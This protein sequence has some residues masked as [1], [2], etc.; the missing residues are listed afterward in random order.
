MKKLIHWEECILFLNIKNLKTWYSSHTKQ[1]ISPD[2]QYLIYWQS[3]L[4]YWAILPNIHYC[5]T[6]RLRISAPCFFPKTSALPT[7]RLPCSRN[8]HYTHVILAGTL[9]PCSMSFETPLSK[10]MH[11]G[12]AS[13]KTWR[14]L[15]RSQLGWKAVQFEW[16]HI[17]KVAGFVCRHYLQ[18]SIIL[19]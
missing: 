9:H 14:I 15:Y 17:C 18:F 6:V 8:I 16:N 7:R 10:I 4:C 5:H 2:F 11:C 1:F 19:I 13:V 12:T 3:D